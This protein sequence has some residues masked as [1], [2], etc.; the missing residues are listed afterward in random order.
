[1]PSVAPNELFK[2][3]AEGAL[4]SGRRASYS[5]Q[6]DLSELL[7]V[8]V[9]QHFGDQSEESPGVFLETRQLALVNDLADSGEHALL[10]GRYLVANSDLIIFVGLLLQGVK[11][12]I[13]YLP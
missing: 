10:L 9:S 1:M 8:G 4:E 13:D 12:G 3:V 5:L 2:V 7:T 6:D 11:A